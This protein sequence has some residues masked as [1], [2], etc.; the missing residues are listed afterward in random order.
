M[1]YLLHMELRSPYYK[2]EQI[3]A[4]FHLL[5]SSLQTHIDTIACNTGFPVDM[6]QWRGDILHFW[7]TRRLQ[8]SIPHIRP[9]MISRRDETAVGIAAYLNDCPGF[10][11][12][13]KQVRRRYSSASSITSRDILIL[14]SVKLT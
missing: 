8:H 12:I 1:F 5:A 10:T 11:G 2:H 3:F 4:N 6:K 7:I 9:T 13:L 14:L